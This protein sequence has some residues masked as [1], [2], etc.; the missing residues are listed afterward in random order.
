MNRK[1]F[2]LL[3]ISFLF[4]NC[5]SIFKRIKANE[6]SYYKI[7]GRK[8]DATIS[9][10][11]CK[12]YGVVNSCDFINGKEFCSPIWQA[13]IF[14]LPRLEEC[15]ISKYNGSYELNLPIGK[16]IIMYNFSTSFNVVTD[17]I[18]CKCQEAIKI[19]AYLMTKGTVLY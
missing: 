4:S 18:L 10:D 12:V 7:V 8:I 19:D 17:S 6:E 1:I 16:S 9:K 13:N 11:S 15:T 3:L 5:S 2:Y 14:T